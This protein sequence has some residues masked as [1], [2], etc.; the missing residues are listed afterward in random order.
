MSTYLWSTGVGASSAGIFC[1]R[2]AF[3][4]QR[5]CDSAFRYD[6]PMCLG[7]NLGILVSSILPVLKVPNV[8][9]RH[10][11]RRVA[12]AEVIFLRVW[13]TSRH[14]DLMQ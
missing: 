6:V 7:F 8:R 4:A 10:M 5:V 14:G 12:H 1:F 3:L 9:E 2:A 13:D 11:H